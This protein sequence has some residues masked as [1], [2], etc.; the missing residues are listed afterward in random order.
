MNHNAPQWKLVFANP[1]S[2]QLPPV[3]QRHRWRDNLRRKTG[4]RFTMQN[5]Y[6]QSCCFFTLELGPEKAAADNSEPHLL[7]VNAVDGRIRDFTDTF[8][9]FVG[10]MRYVRGIPHQQEKENE[11]MRRQLADAFQ[12]LI[13]REIIQPGKA[14][15]VCELRKIALKGTRPILFH[16]RAADDT[17]DI[18]G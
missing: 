13:E 8:Q 4:G 5:A 11:R 17:D 10:I 6:S 14:D 1:P 16:L 12:H 18:G 7:F 9:R 15:P 2:V 3:I